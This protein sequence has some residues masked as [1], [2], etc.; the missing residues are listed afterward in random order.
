MKW[1]TQSSR[2]SDQRR[3]AEVDR[4]RR[5][6]EQKRISEAQALRQR[7]AADRRRARGQG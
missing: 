1:N 5:D 7:Q 6:A 2:A 4:A 3:Q